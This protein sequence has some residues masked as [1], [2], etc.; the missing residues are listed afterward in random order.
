MNQPIVTPPSN[1]LKRYLPVIA[2]AV[3][4]ALVL[5]LLLWPK[6]DSSSSPDTTGAA[7]TVPSG[8]TTPATD[9]SGSVAVDTS[10]PFF[11]D[12][13]KAG[14]PQCDVFDGT[15][16]VPAASSSLPTMSAT[17]A[18]LR[19]ATFIWLFMLRFSYARSAFMRAAASTMVS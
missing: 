11:F 18:P 6:D 13:A 4:A 15:T 14:R 7:T 3:V 1:A 2:I 12:E 8:N 5:A 17:A 9:G 10:A 19:S 16:T